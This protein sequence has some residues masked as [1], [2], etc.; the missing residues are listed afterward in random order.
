M[1]FSTTTPTAAGMACIK[2][3]DTG[4]VAPIIND[5]IIT[6]STLQ[7]W[8][9]KAEIFFD[10]RKIEETD[11]V[12]NVL[13]SFSTQTIVNWIN[14]NEDTIKALPWAEFMIQLKKTA[15]TPGWH[16]GIPSSLEQWLISS[17]PRAYPFV[18]G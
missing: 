3:H 17:N 2:Y 15:L 13:S 18:P 1:S 11:H 10:A 7:L 9:K 6:P 8:K 16:H 14:E 4:K 5:S 12:K